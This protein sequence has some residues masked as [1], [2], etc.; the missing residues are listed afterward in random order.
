MS[1]FLQNGRYLQLYIIFVTIE[2]LVIL[3]IFVLIVVLH[4]DNKCT[5]K[6]MIFLYLLIYV[7][8]IFQVLSPRI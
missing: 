4:A 6:N 2:L 7:F 1:D 8:N 3:P 5:N